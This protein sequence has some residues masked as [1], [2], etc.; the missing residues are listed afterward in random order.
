[1]VEGDHTVE[2][3]VIYGMYSGLALLMDVYRPTTPNGYGAIFI[4]GSGWRA[5]LEWNARPLK[6][7]GQ[8]EVYVPSMT[9]AGYTVFALT[10]RALPRFVYP[11]A[12]EDV[13]RAVRFVR[14]NAKDYGIDPERI[15][16]VGGSSG[17]HLV[18][19]IG[20]LDGAGNPESEDPIERESSKVQCVV[21]RAAPVDF[22]L[23]EKDTPFLDFEHPKGGD[24]TS[25]AYQRHVGASPITYV[26]S[27]CPPFLLLHGDADET[28]KINQSEA[29]EK[30][31]K[32]A[33]VVVKFV[34][35]LG[36]GHGATFANP[37]NP[38]NYRG[39]VVA[40]LNEHLKQ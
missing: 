14:H 11:A 40:W 25:E 38:P 6:N 29:M 3:N 22:L 32:E 5:P 9:A 8:Q 37:E 20:V 24:T 10:H 17:G 34:R 18:S 7:S 16:A 30:A 33:G 4:S 35:V 26:S 1:M 19:M 23:R 2:Q 39:E 13:Q 21:A 12:V 36:G 28:V 27:D 31:L 15:G